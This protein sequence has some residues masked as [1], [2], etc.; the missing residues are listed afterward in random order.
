MHRLL[1]RS[2]LVLAVAAGVAGIAGCGSSS[3]DTSSTASSAS[4]GYGAPATSAT[5]AAGTASGGAAATISTAKIPLGTILVNGSTRPVYLFEADTGTTSTC[6]GACAAAWPPV[7]TKGTPKATGSARSAKL[8]TTKRADGTLQ[9]TYAGHPLYTFA[10]DTT[11]GKATGE[12]SNAFGAG[13]YV[14][15]PSGKKIEPSSGS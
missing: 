12:D 3:S 2:A 13:W 6:T 8:G 4:N 1:L 11:A 7:V 9:V 10:R 5:T 15:A 14:L